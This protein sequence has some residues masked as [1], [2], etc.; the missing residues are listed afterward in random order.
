MPEGV[1]GHGRGLLK[2]HSALLNQNEIFDISDARS[3]RLAFFGVTFGRDRVVIYIEP[4]NAVQNTSRTG[5]VRPDGS[6]LKWDV[7]QDEF[8]ANMPAVL[9][10]FIDRLIAENSKDSHFDTIRERLKTLKDLFRISRYRQSKNGSLL[11]NPDME[12]PLGTGHAAETNRVSEKKAGGSGIRPG[13]LA[14]LLLSELAVEG[15]GVAAEVVSPDPFPKLQWASETEQLRDRAAEY[16]RT[17]NLIIA[18]KDFQGLRDLIAYFSKGHQH[19]PELLPVIEDVVKE[20]FE[21]VL[22]E[23]VAGALSF[24][25]RQHWNLDDFDRAIS[26]EALTTVVMQRYWMCGQ[27]RRALGSKIRG[28][29]GLVGQLEAVHT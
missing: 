7:W 14:T 21:Q 18:N 15:G 10:E 8:R 26:R 5:L 22:I 19:T 9:R 13:S 6:P 20:A 24:R 12:A 1:D 28:F 23:C 17:D 11:A 29:N 16:I 4:E 2:G 25:Q 3:N 27:I